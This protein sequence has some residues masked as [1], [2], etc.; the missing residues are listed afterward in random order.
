MMIAGNND[1]F[2]QY[3]SGI[4]SENSFCPSETSERDHFVVAVG[5]GK[6][7]KSGMTYYII[8]NSFGVEWGEEGYVRI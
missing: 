4:I 3:E 6:D 5:F 8:K 1:M 2:L 7:A